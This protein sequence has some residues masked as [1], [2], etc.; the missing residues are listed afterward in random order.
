MTENHA[1]FW[2]TTQA[3]ASYLSAEDLIRVKLGAEPS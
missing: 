2:S 3:G 1:A